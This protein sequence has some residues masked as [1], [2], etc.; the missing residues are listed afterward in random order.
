M[1]IT[2]RVY[3]GDEDYARMRALLR[4]IYPLTVPAVY[5]TVG[6][7]DWWRWT[8]AEGDDIG[9]ARLWFANDDLVGFAY[10][11]KDE[12]DLMVH[13]DH[14]AI[15][16]AMLAWAEARRV[17]T[18]TTARVEGPIGFNAWSFATDTSREDTLRRRGYA[19]QEGEF[20][21]FRA[22]ALEAPVPEPAPP[23]G[24]AVRHVRGED[25]LARRVA[26]HRNAFAPSRMTAAKHRA[27]MASPTYRPDLDLVAEAPDGS[28]AAFCIVWFDP[29][30]RIGV[31]E[32]VGTHSAHRRRGLATALLCAGMRRL[33]S[34]G[35]RVA[36]VNSWAVAPP[37]AALYDAAGLTEIGR[38]HRWKRDLVDT[39]RSDR[40]E[41]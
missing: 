38:N 12:V 35:A 23:P 27:V 10:P 7:L 41:E 19:K 31:F 16:D 36:H 40:S 18:A 6:D 13:P 3:A 28:F 9:G 5:C 4:V 15:E 2:D 37:A 25:D 17:E 33:Q 29:D 21:C 26:V 30:N 8:H 22:R 1:A 24:Y 20:L 32:P 39:R 11:G 34:L 14:R